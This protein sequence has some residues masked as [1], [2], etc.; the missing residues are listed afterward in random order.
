MHAFTHSYIHVCLSF[1]Y[2]YSFLCFVVFYLS[3]SFLTL[4]HFYHVFLACSIYSF[5]Y[6]Y[7]IFISYNLIF[8]IMSSTCNI[9]YLV[10]LY[11]HVL[12]QTLISYDIYLYVSI[13]VHFTCTLSDCPI[14]RRSYRTY[15]YM[16][17]LIHVLVFLSILYL[18]LSYIMHDIL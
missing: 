8:P 16:E 17:V 15:T 10:N 11:L 9:L 5:K 4:M 7:H 18:Y 1:V 6:V 12:Y 3:L 13:L 2:M 14:S